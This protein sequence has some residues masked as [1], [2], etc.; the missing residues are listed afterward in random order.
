[1]K[2]VSSLRQEGKLFYFI[3]KTTVN[4]IHN[5]ETLEAIPLNSKRNP[6]CL[7]LSLLFNN[8][9]IIRQEKDIRYK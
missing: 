8:V 3:S 7:Q 6:G 2:I 1:M 5:G 4:I 9:N